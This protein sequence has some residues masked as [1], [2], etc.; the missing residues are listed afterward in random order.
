MRGLFASV[1][2]GVVCI[3]CGDS[4][5]GISPS[6]ENPEGCEQPTV[7][8]IRWTTD[9]PG[10]S[11]VEYGPDTNYG[12]ATP[13]L[14]AET[15]D[16][17]VVLAG[18][19]AAA[20]W[21]WR[22]VSMVGGAR[23]ASDDATI[24]ACP[25]AEDLPAL[26]VR[27]YDPARTDLGWV[28]GSNLS[29]KSH[30]IVF[31]RDGSYV[32]W[33]FGGERKIVSRARLSRNGADMLYILANQSHSVDEGEIVRVPL[34][35]GDEIRTR[36]VMSHHDFIELAN[37]NYV[38]LMADVRETEID[39]EDPPT[40][41][42]V[43]G[44]TLVEVEPDGT[45]VRDIVSVWDHFS[46]IG[47]V[48]P[49][50]DR[51]FY[52]QGLDWTHCNGMIYVEEEDALYVSCKH[53]STVLKVD[54]PTGELVW[55]L[56]GDFSDFELVGEGDGFHGQHAIARTEGGFTLFNN[57]ADLRDENDLLWSE[58][59]EFEVDEENGTYERI[60][61]YDA[62]K[63]LYT[64][65]MGGCVHTPN[66]NVHTSWGIRG[67]VRELDPES[68]EIVWDVATSVGHGLGYTTWA[69]SI[70]PIE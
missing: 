27:T 25:P 56:G 4:L 24:E 11:Q 31:N 67:V 62:D 61:S 16:H 28:V 52:P 18:L 41:A 49:K 65:L 48:D 8:V 60:W 53:I 66:G 22:A 30:P 20:T 34:Q 42:S 43:V 17:E 12:Y 36:T 50:T 63:E 9:E 10:T 39:R 21:H 55:R 64:F 19:A 2:V 32:W 29:E 26:T 47:Y 37:G 70:G 54:F 1:V 68:N 38:H 51:R 5:S 69:Q 7:P 13:L 58:A 15:R 14:D 33:R 44:D 57:R 40:V 35:G 23:I 45:V 3:G 59:V 46:P 6:V